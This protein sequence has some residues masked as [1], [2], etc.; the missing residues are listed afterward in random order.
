[1]RSQITTTAKWD[2]CRGV[3]F[4]LFDYS[5]LQG[6]DLADAIE[7]NRVALLDLAKSGHS[8]LLYLTDVTH[9]LITDEALEAF[10]RV[11]KDVNPF[12]KGSAVVGVRG[13]RKF[14]LDIVNKFSGLNTKAFD[15]HEAAKEW[16]SKL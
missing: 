10:K 15:T 9:C 5:N 14:A 6:R 2:E 13:L 12:T 7:A 4:I 3:S 16:L 1:M 11:T 8:E